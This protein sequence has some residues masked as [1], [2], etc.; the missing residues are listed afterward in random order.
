MLTLLLAL[1]CTG[2]VETDT[3]T[4]DE[5]V[6]GTG[7]LALSFRIDDDYRDVMQEPALGPFWGSVY[8]A[9]EVTGIGPDDGALPLAHIHVAEIDLTGEPV[10]AALFVTDPLPNDWVTIL[11]FMDSDSN[12]VPG[13]EDPDSKD[14]VTLPNE[15]EFLV[16]KDAETPAEVFFGFLNP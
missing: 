13:D 12:A 16:V 8:L 9:D 1:A 4:G 10:S 5:D 11:G 2:S 7:T 15:N 3:D 14:P 6:A